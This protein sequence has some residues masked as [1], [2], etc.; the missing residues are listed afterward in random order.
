MKWERKTLG[1][2]ITTKKGFAFESS[3][4]VDSG[5]PV[6]RVSDF[7]LDSISDAD[8][9]YYPL[10]EKQ[11][12]LDFELHTK[13]VIIQTVGS[14]QNNPNSVVGKVVRVPYF[15]EGAL[16]NQNAVKLVPIENVDS[17]FLFY[18]LKTEEFKGHV[19][20]EA[21][22]AANQASITLDTIKSFK[23]NIPDYDTQ[24]YIGKILAT[25]DDLI[26]NNQKLIKLL[27]EAAQR[28]YK[29]WFVDLRFPGYEDV[30]IVDGVPKGWEEK[31]ISD[32]ADIKYGYAFD[33]KLFNS[34]GNGVPIIRIRNIPDGITN[35]YTTEEV[36]DDF[37]A[38]NGDIIIGMDGEFHINSWNGESAYLVQRTCSI[39]PYDNGMKGY[40]LQAI[41]EPIKFFEATLVGATVAHL[42]KKHLDTI[43]VKIAPNNL[44]K[45]FQE[46]YKKRQA[47]LNQ[48]RKL[49]EARDRLLPKLI[50]GEVEV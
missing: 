42:G 41:Y 4:Y 2:I 8:L 9:K 45:P 36:D 15:L 5:V 43:K 44:M 21:R 27:E 22:G 10:E 7:T 37:L 30:E 12:Y 35:D 48:N 39:R 23:F 34:D 29:E 24:K 33:G 38:H 25:Y 3:R 46:L 50:S 18:R 6:V 31:F 26:E 11:N 32:I 19:I 13:D 16:L 1:E 40:L 14:W 47:L 17:N 20:G 49:S 28:L